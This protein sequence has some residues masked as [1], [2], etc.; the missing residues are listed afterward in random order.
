MAQQLGDFPEEAG[1][2]QQPRGERSFL[3]AP[4]CLAGKYGDMRQKCTP[5]RASGHVA[6]EDALLVARLPFHELA[7]AAAVGRGDVMQHARRRLVN[8]LEARA[9]ETKREIDILEV[10]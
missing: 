4:P 10:A 7:A 2:T 9:A 1:P 5:E 6:P 8:R 3:P